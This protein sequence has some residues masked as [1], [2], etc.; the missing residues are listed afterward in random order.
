MLS[1]LFDI[2]CC[3]SETLMRYDIDSLLFA[4]GDNVISLFIL[5][6]GE[7]KLSRSLVS[8]KELV[9]HRSKARS[10]VAEASIYSATYH[11]DAICLTLCSVR[12]LPISRFLKL[13][14]ENLKLSSVWSTHLARNL[15][16]ARYRSEILTMKKVSERLDAWLDWHSSDFPPK[17]KWKEI[18]AE[19]GVSPEAL[20]RELATRK[21]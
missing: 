8:G 2:L 16:S 4:R 7:I 12:K 3:E 14:N 15:Q 5:E 11:C 20:Y 10:I 9:L 17:G 13:I 6:E 1:E 18:A 19:I 21:L